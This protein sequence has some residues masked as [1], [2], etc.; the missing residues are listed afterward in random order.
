M[1]DFELKA[2]YGE[3]SDE[4]KEAHR[5]A[6][7]AALEAS[8]DNADLLFLLGLHLYFDGQTERAAKFFQTRGTTSPPKTR[9]A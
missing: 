9:M 1:S 2:L 6:L 5:E 8:P 3:D 4:K 7:A